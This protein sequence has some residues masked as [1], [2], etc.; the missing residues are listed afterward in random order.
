M[1]VA[2]SPPMSV[3]AGDLYRDGLPEEALTRRETPTYAQI[4]LYYNYKI[5]TDF[6]EKWGD[7]KSAKHYR[8]KAEALK[9]SIIKHFWNEEQGLFINGYTKDGKLDTVIFTLPSTGLSLPIYFPK[10]GMIICLKYSPPF[11]ITMIM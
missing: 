6:S 9:K 7:R 5:G 3:S 1:N 4:M 2:L 11:L 10:N 8:M